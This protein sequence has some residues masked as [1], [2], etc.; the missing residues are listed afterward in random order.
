MK[1]KQAVVQLLT[2]ATGAGNSFSKEEQELERCDT[3]K[4][5]FIKFVIFGKAV[6]EIITPFLMQINVRILT[7]D[8]PESTL[9]LGRGEREKK[10]K[11]SSPFF[12]TSF[13]KC[14]FPQQ[15]TSQSSLSPHPV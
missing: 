14:G 8:D 15:K 9:N 5:P 11:K 10:K 13:I 12:I 4:I 7:C 2:T 6:N 1:A 3:F